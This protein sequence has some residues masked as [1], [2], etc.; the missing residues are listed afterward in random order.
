MRKAA[1]KSINNVI[2]AAAGERCERQCSGNSRRSLQKSSHRGTRKP[3]S[4]LFNSSHQGDVWKC[5]LFYDSDL[6]CGR[7][8]FTDSMQVWDKDVDLAN[9]QIF[10]DTAAFQAQTDAFKLEYVGDRSRG[11]QVEFQLMTTRPLDREVRSRYDLTLTC[12][13]A[14]SD[15]ANEHTRSRRQLFT[16]YVEDKN[17][18]EPTFTQDMVTMYVRENAPVGTLIGRVTA[19]D[20]DSGD[21][22]V[23]RYRLTKN[24]SESLVKV[25]STS[26]KIRTNQIFDRER[27]TSMTF[28]VTAYDAARP[29]LNATQSVLLHVTDVNDNA[30]LFQQASYIFKVAEN[31]DPQRVGRVIASDQDGGQNGAIRFRLMRSLG[32]H[33]L[34]PWKMRSDGTLLLRERGLDYEKINRY[35]LTVVAFDGGTPSLSATTTLTVVVLDENDHTPR[36]M[37]PNL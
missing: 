10:C 33:Y 8:C 28:L 14:N 35:H 27:N 23:I 32:A 12:R 19:N 36:F 13:D 24:P 20:I 30:P 34:M 15:G 31:S 5:L 21:N 29:Q 16:V 2:V 7:M 17:D 9:S 22:A 18:N 4:S 6:T 25:D 11:R 3:T 1:N 37:F 26:G